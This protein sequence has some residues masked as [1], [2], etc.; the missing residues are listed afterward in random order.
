MVHVDGDVVVYRAGFAAEHTLYHLHYYA[1]GKQATKTFDGAKEYEAFLKDKDWSPVDY[2]VEPEI[3]VEPEEAAVYNVR[4]I[5]RSICEDLQIDPETELRVYLSGETNFRNGVATIKPYK[6]NRDKSR[7]PVHA[8]ALKDYVRRAYN[9]K[10][11]DGQEADDDMAIAHFDMFCK[12]P[13][14]T[15][16]STIDKD[17]N[18]IPGLHY[19]FV[20]KESYY[21]QPFEG[22]LNFY[23]QCLTGDTTDNIPGIR[24]VGPVKAGKLIPDDADP[25]AALHAVRG[26]YREAYGDDAEKVLLEV[27][28]LLWIRRN[29]DE[30]WSPPDGDHGADRSD[31][32]P[33]ECGVRVPEGVPAAQRGV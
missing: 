5:L 8:P 11:S 9:C 19:N 17:L 24:G 16:I 12:D 20:T 1:D 13:D 21:V 10:T 6:G 7:K 33:S 28:R 25:G 26:A 30:W 2:W 32:G 22:L 18:M 15:V 31:G 3:M 29:H 14:S 27:G 4:S 23:R